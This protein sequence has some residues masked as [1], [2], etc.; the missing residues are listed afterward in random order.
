VS[1]GYVV[2]PGGGCGGGEELVRE[3]VG[4]WVAPLGEVFVMFTLESVGLGFI[5]YSKKR[6]FRRAP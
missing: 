4:F 6:G 1:N 3:V 2:Q 5:T